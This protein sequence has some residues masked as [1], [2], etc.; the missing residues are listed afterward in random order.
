MATISLYADNVVKLTQEL[1]ANDARQMNGFLKQQ[2]ARCDEE[3]ERLNEE[4]LGFAK[5]AKLLDGDKEMTAYLTERGNYDMKYESTRL[6][7]ETLDLKLN[8]VETELA[9]VSPAASRLQAARN[10]LAQ[11][12]TRYTEQNP[13][14]EEHKERIATLEADLRKESEATN[15]A[16]PSASESPIAVNLYLQRVELQTQR[17]VLADQLQKIDEVRNRLAE[18]LFQLP[19]KS[20]EYAKMKSK[21]AS[22]E[23]AR[24]LLASRQREAELYADNSLGYYRVL[25]PARVEDVVSDTRT[26]KKILAGIAG[27]ALG[28]LGVAAWF[29]GRELMD[30][31]IKTPADLRWITKVPVLAALPEDIA[32]DAQSRQ[33]WAFRTWTRLQPKLKQADGALVCGLLSGEAGQHTTR[34]AELLA[35]AAAWRGAAVL[36]ISRQPVAERPSL[37]LTQALTQS[38]MEADQWLANQSGVVC[39]HADENWTWNAPQRAMLEG[40]LQLWSRHAKAIVFIELPPATEPEAL[41]MAECLPLVLWCGAKGQSSSESL[42]TALATYRDA[43]CKLLGSFLDSAY[44]LRPSILN[45]LAGTALLFA[46]T[47]APAWGQEETIALAQPASLQDEAASAAPATRPEP[48]AAPTQAKLDSFALGPGDAVNIELF[49][50]ASSLRKEVV[51]R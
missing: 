16:P 24:Q 38:V 6:D 35:D 44:R 3:M 11:L 27:A 45:R 13:V 10:E 33:A 5:E 23:S 49:G 37:P 26:S 46:T 30:R 41:L 36:F 1:Q 18:K 7:Y 20:M 31:R 19:R 8:S 40:A 51:V 34:V 47:C 15:A 29:I 14:V 50:H 32:N 2:L 43:G 12:L 28:F 21:Q 25:Q 4:M 17:K 22:L 42:A 39:L 9:K 48:P